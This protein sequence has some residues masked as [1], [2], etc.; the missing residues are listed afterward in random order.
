MPLYRRKK[1]KITH[2]L[3]LT[4]LMSF[5]AFSTLSDEYV[6]P[7][8]KWRNQNAAPKVNVAQE[9]DFK[10]FGENGYRVEEAPVSQR[11]VASESEEKDEEG[12][13]PSSASNPEPATPQLR[14]WPFK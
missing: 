13:N 9:K 4:L 14:S 2:A 10:E 8:F 11:D 3:T 1:M 7:S 6:A 12:R 5:F